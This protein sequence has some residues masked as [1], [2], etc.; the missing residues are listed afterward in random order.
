MNL[1]RTF[2]RSETRVLEGNAAARAERIWKKKHLRRELTIQAGVV[3]L[4]V[5]L[6]DLAVLDDES[7]ALT[8]GVAEDGGTVEGQVE[9]RSQLAVR[10]GEEA[11]A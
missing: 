9:G 2:H 4:D 11:D 6:G 7:V 1:D 10:V 5:G 3:G 8:A